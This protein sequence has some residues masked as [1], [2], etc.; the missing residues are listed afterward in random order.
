MPNWVYNKVYFSGDKDK[1]KKLKEFVKTEENEFD[2]NKIIPMP[3]SLKLS[4]GSDED[5]AVMCAKAKRKNEEIKL[6]EYDLKRRT[7]D[8]WVALGEKYINNLNKYGATTWYDWSCNHWGTKWNSC[9]ASWC[10]DS[11][12]TFNT[13]WSE[14]E[15]VY[16]R[17]ADLFPDVEFSVEF[18]NEDIGCDCGTIKY[19]DGHFNIDYVD[20]VEFACEVWGYDP[21]EFL[22]EQYQ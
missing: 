16:R 17:L 6:T 13:A 9:G 21:E 3:E 10:G 4:A 14:P 18:A 15:P 7:V 2:F 22:E 20:S 8:E 19:S 11:F 1:I 12:V 5:T